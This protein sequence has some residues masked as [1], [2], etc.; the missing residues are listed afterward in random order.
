MT[1][2]E[3]TGLGPELSMEPARKS[4]MGALAWPSNFRLVALILALL[5]LPVLHE[6]AIACL[7]NA[8][9]THS[10][11]IPP[12]ALAVVWL[13][14]SD[15]ARAVLAP[16]ALGLVVMGFGLMVMAVSYLM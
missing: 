7:R 2:R 12:L 11:L 14:R 9:F 15:I 1:V 8:D 4:I 16:R 13:R 6:N 3:T 5:Y 10:L